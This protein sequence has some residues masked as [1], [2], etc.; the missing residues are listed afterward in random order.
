MP[1]LSRLRLLKDI[2]VGVAAALLL[3]VAGAS[4]GLNLG[5]Y[6]PRA[7]ALLLG[8]GL[9]AGTFTINLKEMT[10]QDWKLVAWAVT[11]GVAA[12][13]LFVGGIV[14]G[15]TGNPNAWVIG[16]NVAQMDPLSANALMDKTSL[17]PRAKD[18][19]KAWAAGDDP[20]TVAAV[21][22]MIAAQAGFHVNFGIPPEAIGVHDAHTF[23]VYFV[24]NFAMMAT[25]VFVFKYAYRG[26]TAA[27]VLVML[28]LL[29]TTVFVGAQWF[30]MFGIALTGLFMRPD[31]ESVSSLI[32]K[33]LERCS[34]FAY[35]A[36]G[37]I[38]GLLIWQNGLGLG[39]LG[40]GLLI[41]TAAYVS[42]A[43]V[44]P[45]LMRGL[46]RDFTKTDR[47]LLARA[48]QNGLTAC[49]LALSTGTIASILP[50]IITT[51]VLY[52]LTNKRYEHRLAR[53]LS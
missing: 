4:Y 9:L 51:Q 46:E 21:V 24:Q 34:G 26:S 38:V 15:V 45:L 29:A 52:F 27:R 30:W 6:T 20:F 3:G 42:Q 50:A 18:L 22:A 13:A 44:A 1:L 37:C 49:L 33:V 40:L 31:D 36:A 17:S 48:H 32:E 39:D 23:G 10:K 12:K 16:V 5:G 2:R 28:G 43:L 41:G 8:I 14:F 25:L 11:A 35:V 7:I 19:L 53:G 47:G